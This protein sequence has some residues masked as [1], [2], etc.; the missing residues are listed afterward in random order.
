MFSVYLQE[1]ALQ[2][3]PGIYIEETLH[4]NTKP[5]CFQVC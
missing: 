4:F 2:F 3:Y 1:V 5:Y